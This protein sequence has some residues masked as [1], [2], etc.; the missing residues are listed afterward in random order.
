MQLRDSCDGI[1]YP[2]HWG[3]FGGAIEPG[4][5]SSEALIRELQEE[6]DFSVGIHKYI[7]RITFF[8]NENNKKKYYYRDYYEIKITNEELKDLKLN[9][10]AEFKLISY[11]KLNKLKLVP[12]DHFMIDLYRMNTF[13]IT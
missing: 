12:Y 9:E 1:W 2:N 10:G 8:I 6:L 3:C 11:K 13:L 7:N 4:E 5:T